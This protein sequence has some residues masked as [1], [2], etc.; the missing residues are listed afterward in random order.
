VAR[1]GRSLPLRPRWIRPRRAT[2]PTNYT[3]TP[4]D[5]VGLSDTP[6][7]AVAA[8]QT[9]PTD[10]VGITDA[11]AVSVQFAPTVADTVGI[12]D[13]GSGG[14]IYAP[15]PA[16]TV[17][18]TDTVTVV[19]TQTTGP[20]DPV[21]V[22][23]TASSVQARTGTAADSVGVTDAP[24]LGPGRN[25]ADAVGLTDTVTVNAGVGVSAADP[26]GLT[27][28][29]ALSRTRTPADPVG[30]TD[31]PITIF[32]FGA[33][34]P[35]NPVRL[36]DTV[37]ATLTTV[38]TISDQ[39]GI[40]DAEAVY[41]VFALPVTTTAEPDVDLRPV[42]LA[43]VASLSG[44]AAISLDAPLADLEKGP[45]RATIDIAAGTTELTHVVALAGTASVKIEWFRPRLHVVAR[46]TDVL[47]RQITGVVQTMTLRNGPIFSDPTLG[48][49]ATGGVEP[50]VHGPTSKPVWKLTRNPG[51]PA[52]TGSFIA[53][54]V[55]DD[56]AAGASVTVSMYVRAP[57]G[58]ATALAITND[59]G[60][61][62]VL[63]P[64]AFAAHDG[65]W[66]HYLATFTIPKVWA[67][68][69]HRLRLNVTNWMEWS[70]ATLTVT[71]PLSKRLTIEPEPVP[72]P[73][74]RRIDRVFAVLR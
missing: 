6:A 35:V 22:T 7:T 20:A 46:L 31:T 13:I 36:T 3:A 72:E 63:T 68:G 55:F 1:L 28:T 70:D 52:G 64:P 65:T 18:L 25:P 41:G 16:D 43:D 61:D 27:D 47:D 45:Q 50:G 67:A 49:A 73:E 38:R 5:P 69:V 62:L 26:V 34:P 57:V 10:P 58:E 15:S 32:I 56:L 12:T 39:I 29:V 11:V 19:Q 40:T 60:T 8:T 71:A 2:G 9:V 44:T 74:P 24:A 4:N 59:P 53:A 42:E 30:V 37:T 23:D 51:V 17:G 21:G 54:D 14:A 48:P 66:H 33:L